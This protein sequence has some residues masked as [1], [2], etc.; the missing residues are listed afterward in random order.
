MSPRKIAMKYGS[1]ITLGASLVAVSVPSF[2]VTTFTVL[3]AAAATATDSLLALGTD[4]GIILFTIGV[5]V[6]LAV[7]GWNVFRGGAKKA[8]RL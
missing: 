5:P 6:L 1:Q 4:V 7:V 2:A 8:S 3:P